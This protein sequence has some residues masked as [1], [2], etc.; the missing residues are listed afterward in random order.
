MTDRPA[1]PP[2]T[3]PAAVSEARRALTCLYL[4]TAPEVAADVRRKVEAAFA[5]LSS[6]P[7]PPAAT[8]DPDGYD[9]ACDDCD[10]HESCDAYDHGRRRP[11]CDF[12]RASPPA[13]DTSGARVTTFHG[14]R[15][16]ARFVNGE[17]TRDEYAVSRSDVET[18]PSPSPASTSTATDDHKDKNRG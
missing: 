7:A 10:T 5:A 13:P 9:L 11:C 8:R 12:V 6:P 3:A 17:I 18:T 16:F 2:G 15:N 4:A 1:S 14:V